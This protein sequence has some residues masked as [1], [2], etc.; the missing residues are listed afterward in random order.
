MIPKSLYHACAK[1]TCST[2]EG[3]TKAHLCFHESLWIMNRPIGKFGFQ[4]YQFSLSS[5]K[6]KR[7]TSI[8]CEKPPSYPIPSQAPSWRQ[9]HN[10][11]LYMWLVAPSSFSEGLCSAEW[12]ALSA[13][14]WSPK[15]RFTYS[16]LDIGQIPWLCPFPTLILWELP[17]HQSTWLVVRV[18]K[19]R[20]WVAW[21][22]ISSVSQVRP[23][24]LH[25]FPPHIN[26]TG[27]ITRAGK[28]YYRKLTVE[29]KTTILRKTKIF[30]GMRGKEGNTVDKTLASIQ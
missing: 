1:E 11:V 29:E 30:R 3:S 18:H 15:E 27:F 28:T 25:F 20:E 2:P 7:N 4:K 8:H 6:F 5:W 22:H 17:G 21:R 24:T 19:D 13:L 9:W 14:L 10:R 16:F 23:S 26:W 12:M